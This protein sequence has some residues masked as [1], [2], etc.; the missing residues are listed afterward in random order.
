MGIIKRDSEK[1]FT[2][3]K[4]IPRINSTNAAIVIG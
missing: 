4:H 1:H 3:S 2:T